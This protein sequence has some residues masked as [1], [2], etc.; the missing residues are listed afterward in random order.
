VNPAESIDVIRLS[1]QPDAADYIDAFSARNKRRRVN[2]FVGVLS[3][4]GFAFAVLAILAGQP[5]AA[6]LGVL[7]GVLFPLAV[8]FVVKSSTNALWRRNPALQQPVQMV[9]DAR[10][11]GGDAPVILMNPGAMH[12]MTGSAQHRW[13]EIGK[14]LETPRVFVV[15]L[16]RAFFLLAKRGLTDPAQQ[17]SLRRLLL[18]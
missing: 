6:V 17:E 11:A 13:A 10:G 2:W 15:H 5:G 18:R 7:A 12:V 16:D 8:P 1:W 4:I 9:V 3:A 14:V